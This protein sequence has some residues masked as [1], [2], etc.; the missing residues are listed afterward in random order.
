MRSLLYTYREEIV[1]KKPDA[2][3]FTVFDAKSG[4]LK[5]KLDYETSLLTTMDTLIGRYRWLKVPFGTKSAPEMYKRTMEKMLEGIDH[6]YTMMDDILVDGRDIPHHDSV[7][8]KVLYRTKNCNLK[9]NVDKVR[10]PKQQVPYMGNVI[11]ADGLKL[12]P[13]KVRAIMD[14]PPPTTKEDVRRFLGSWFWRLYLGHTS[15]GNTS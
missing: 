6:A 14:M 1:A 7:L 13:E 2:K 9:L 4:Y 10:V 5:M 11:S 15:S 8:E 12:D 3:V